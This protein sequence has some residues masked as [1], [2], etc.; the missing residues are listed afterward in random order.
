MGPVKKPYYTEK[1]TRGTWLVSWGR[2]STHSCMKNLARSNSSTPFTSVLP[3]TIEDILHLRESWYDLAFCL[4]LDLM[5][6]PPPNE[7][8]YLY[9]I[10]IRGIQNLE[11]PARATIASTAVEEGRPRQ[12]EVMME[13]DRSFTVMLGFLSTHSAWWAGF[14]MLT[15]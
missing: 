15:S 6:V 14:A 1:N 2:L 13:T 4:N 11:G 10:T 7:R 8:P 5:G 3:F 9:Y 12:T